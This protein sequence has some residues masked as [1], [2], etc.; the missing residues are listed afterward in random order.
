MKNINLNKDD[1]F[2]VLVGV[3]ILV[4]LTQVGSCI[5]D[6]QSINVVGDCYKLQSRPEMCE[7]LADRLD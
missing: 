4:A 3:A 6:L 2:G 7:K 1:V 5:I